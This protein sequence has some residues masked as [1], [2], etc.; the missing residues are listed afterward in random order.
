M[1]MHEATFYLDSTITAE[2][3]TTTE[4]QTSEITGYCTHYAC[5]CRTQTGQ[6]F[7]GHSTQFNMSFC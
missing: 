2:A 7:T 5:Y 1:N 3:I 6:W 4:T